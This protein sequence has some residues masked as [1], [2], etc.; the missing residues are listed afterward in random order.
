MII[1]DRNFYNRSIRERL[2]L[3]V[4]ELAKR[5]EVTRQT[6]HNYEIGRYGVFRPL[7]R[8]I[9]LE[10]DKAIA[11][12]CDSEKIDICRELRYRRDNRL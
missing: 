6:I 2:G 1:L 5:V 12:C 11:K 10:L 3:S 8:V 4:L 9:E 7:E